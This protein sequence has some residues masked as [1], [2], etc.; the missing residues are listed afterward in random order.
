LAE[1]S[2]S[3]VY[4][5][6]G[7]GVGEVVVVAVRDRHVARSGSIE[8]AQDTEGVVDRVAALDADQR[9]DLARAM[10]AHHVVRGARQLE[11]IGVTLVETIDDIDLF[12]H[13]LHRV[14]ALQ[15]GRNIDGPELRAGHSFAKP[16][17][18][19]VQR[20]SEAALILADVDLRKM[21]LR[22][23]V[24][25]PRKIVVAVDQRYVMQ[26]ALDARVRGRTLRLSQ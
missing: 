11:R 5:I 23:L 6:R 16:R 13:G 9:R 3:V 7:G 26:D 2:E 19:S 14:S 22:T 8:L 4:R 21:I 20:R 18:V 1:G 25:L 24:V 10:N 12:E 15:S 17:D